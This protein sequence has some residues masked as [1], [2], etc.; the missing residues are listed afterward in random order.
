[1]TR[2]AK[3]A[4]PP[5]VPLRPPDEVMRLERLGSFHQT[6]ISFMRSLLRRMAREAWQVTRDR[7]DLDDDGYGTAIYRVE[8]PHG[9]FSLVAFS[10]ALAPE[11]R[12]DR[13]IA[14][15]WDATFALTLGRPDEATIERLRQNVPK[16]EAGRCSARE[17]VLSRANKSVR[18]FETVVASLAEGHQPPTTALAAVG[19]LMRT[20]AVYGNGKF[21]LADRPVLHDGPVLNGP[22]Q[23]EMLTVYLIRNFTFDLVDHIA[24]RRNPAGAVRLASGL[25]RMLGIG[26]ATGL[27]MAPFLV[28]HPKLLDRWIA[29]RETAI[30]RVRAV[31]IAEPARRARFMALLDRARRYVADWRTD[32]AR[33]AARIERLG[34]ELAAFADW[35]EDGP[36]GSQRPWDAIAG[37]ARERLS[38][39]A[40]EMMNSLILEPYP[41]LVDDLENEMGSDERM[42]TVP[43]MSLADLKRLIED[44]Y[45]W[46][47]TTDFDRPAAQH[48]FWYVSEEKLEPRLGER[49]HEPGADKEMR[50]GIARD[51]RRL[52]DRLSGAADEMVA[53]FL[54]RE[55]EWRHIVRRVQSLAHCDY[56]EIRDNLLA[57]DCLAI[58]LLR[59]KLS[60][61]GASKFDPKSDRWVRITLYQGAPTVDDLSRADAD[62]W[63][64]AAP[65]A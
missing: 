11:E 7:F 63:I 62:D 65:E 30:A 39:E 59:C 34:P 32:D 53:E 38:V 22:F 31:E 2:A 6:R 51:V 8:T 14:E 19:Y 41:E 5:A 33:L 23:A 27:G 43:R 56:A 57:E 54:L 40:Q 36:W 42:A 4:A 17:L 37:W 52:Y 28:G 15:K 50:T 55:P 21:G 18:L 29:A 1:M 3:T 49:F 16:Q 26:N 46:A 35:V 44:R 10:D 64:F 60:F 24:A 61:F 12:S 20:T 9:D 13:V 48:L 25:K 58:D 47:L 45:G